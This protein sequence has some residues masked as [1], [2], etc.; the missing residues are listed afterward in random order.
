MLKNTGLYDYLLALDDP[1]SGGGIPLL[2]N[3]SVSDH[4]H[5][6]EVTTTLPSSNQLRWRPIILPNNTTTTFYGICKW[7]R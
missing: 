1:Q 5:R 4:P 7:P 6:P 3:P 2:K